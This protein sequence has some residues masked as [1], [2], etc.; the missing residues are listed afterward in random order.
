MKKKKM[1]AL[2]LATAMVASM[3][4][5]GDQNAP[6]SASQSQEQKET[7]SETPSQESTEKEPEVVLN[8]KLKILMPYSSAVGDYNDETT[9]P[10]LTYIKE[11]TGYDITFDMLP[12]DSPYDKVNA[13]LASDTYYDMIVIGDRDYYTQYAAWGALLD[14][15]EL[16][17]QYAP[18]VKANI[19]DTAAE[20]MTINGTYWAVPNMAPSGRNDSA[21]SSYGLMYRTDVLES[22]GIA[23]PKT[24]DEFTAF[25]QACKDKDPL[26]AGNTNAPFT[27][28]PAMLENLRT[29]ALGGAFG[30]AQEWIEQD[31]E[32]VPYQMTD[33]F[34]EYLD[35]LHELYTKGLLDAE[36]PTNDSKTTTA[37][38][39]G[40]KSAAAVLAYWSVPGLIKTFA[41]S[42]ANATIGY[43][44][45][46]ASENYEA[47]VMAESLN[48]FNSYVVI[49]KVAK[50]NVASIMNFLNLMAEEDIFKGVALGEENVD[51]VVNSD[52]SYSPLEAFFTDR[53][54]GTNY[55]FGTTPS[56]GQYWLA[57]AQKDANQYACY[58]QLNFDFGKY[59]EVNNV[60]DVPCET[61]VSLANGRSLSKTLTR[62]FIVQAIV[63]GV[64]DS[65]LA[66]FRD[67]W[68][69]QCGD[70]L[71]QSYNEW[72]QK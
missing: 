21:N 11:A 34:K 37:K 56:Y 68:K 63:E 25:L 30:I 17:E 2:L 8:K 72:F 1:T 6:A 55:M 50:D 52:G 47:S 12:S 49:P 29:S 46:L 14:M 60:S 38:F 53:N 31:G 4:G 24:V 36:M 43:G 44:A 57:R 26:G 65:S 42:D 62:D 64:T 67:D 23:E 20:I 18:N 10:V 13:I 40:G 5:C 45:P 69:L 66:T 58:A 71:T 51:Y 7:L 48:Q 15:K 54:T 33:N 28:Y 32:L 22:L 16:V 61:F 35:Y 41:E 19:N 27:I 39:T 3:A 9:N 59:I 70:T